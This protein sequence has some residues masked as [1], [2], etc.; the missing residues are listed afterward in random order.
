MLKR[1][2]RERKEYLY[3]KA[4]E[5]QE[6]S[7]YS[8]KKKIQSALQQG[9]KLP[10]ELTLNDKQRLGHSLQNDDA[11]TLVPTIHIDD[12]YA[13]YTAPRILLTTSR[14]P[15]ARL[16]QF[17]K[18]LKLVFPDTIRVNRGST[19]IKDLARICR[20]KDFTDLIIVHA[21]KGEPDGMIIS[22]FP[23]GPTIFFGLVN[24]V[25][26]HDLKEKMDTMSEAK[27]HLIFH[28]FSTP[29]GIRISNILK[30]LFP[31]PKEDSKRIMAFSN[32]NDFIIYRHHTYEKPDYKT[33]TLKEIGP[34][35]DMKAFQIL[36]GTIDMPDS[37][38]E[39]VLRPYMSTARK[40]KAL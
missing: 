8:K 4:H 18:E 14:N 17:A 27:P 23:Y 31:I 11:N 6:R 34:R 26:R 29:L 37:K 13:N 38:T 36:L 12:E 32:E 22:H 35:F 15:S 24:V 5:D 10:T 7:D 1:V 39:W 3:K 28:N 21:H 2:V 25:L 19:V 9:K 30:H 33:V 40:R 20:E 16:M